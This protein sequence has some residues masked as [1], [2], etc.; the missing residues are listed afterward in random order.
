MHES[1]FSCRL[2]DTSYRYT[3]QAA[4]T[5]TTVY[6]RRW[7]LLDRPRGTLLWQPKKQ[8]EC[9]RRVPRPWHGPIAQS[10]KARSP[11]SR[12]IWITPPSGTR[13]SGSGASPSANCMRPVWDM[14]TSPNTTGDSIMGMP[15]PPASVV[16]KRP[17]STFITVDSAGGPR[18]APGEL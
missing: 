11:L 14:E 7:Q 9:Q 12:C 1:L 10:K 5:R 4:T 16:G 13:T 2:T 8:P 18:G 15:K 17:Q 6:G 3:V